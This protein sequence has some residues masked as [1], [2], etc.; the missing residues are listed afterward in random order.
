MKI[1]THVLLLL[2]AHLVF[3]S[4][5]ADAKKRS[6][7]I[8]SGSMGPPIRLDTDNPLL[9]GMTHGETL[10]KFIDRKIRPTTKFNKRCAK[11][12]DELV[13]T[14]EARSSPFNIK[15][16]VKGGSLGKGTSVTDRSDIDL[17]IFFN[18]YNT[19]KGLMKYKD[20]LLKELKTFVEDEWPEHFIYKQTTPFSVQ[21]YLKI[22]EE[23][24]EH[25]VD[26]LPALDITK[27]GRKLSEI[28]QEMLDQVPKVR[29]HYSS[30]LSPLQ[31]KFVTHTDGMATPG[32]VKDVMRLLKYWAKVE[33]V[34]LR[35]YFLELLLVQQ[36][37]EDGKLEDID[38]EAYLY[39]TLKQLTQQRK[40]AI[41]FSDNYNYMD[42]VPNIKTPFLLDPANPFKNVAPLS[43]HEVDIVV[44]KSEILLER[45]WPGSPHLSDE[46]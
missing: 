16:I 29:D 25:E 35:S 38:T 1:H 45:G 19:V 14:L 13:R 27:K 44:R 26:L 30:C 46:L 18:D 24:A 17:V 42:Y 36:W 41:A 32:K 28:Y 23:D 31:L 39:R 33:D 8:R 9:P 3:L 40:M 15:G 6:N 2:T 7:S 5:L 10:T 12:I 34:P 43:K 21:F 4:T 37:R 11:I 20:K 22:D